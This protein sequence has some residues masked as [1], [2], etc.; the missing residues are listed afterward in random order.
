MHAIND[1]AA[2]L[3]SRFNLLFDPHSRCVWQSACGQFRE[4][5]LS[6]SAGIRLP[7][8]EVWVLPFSGEGRVLPFLEHFSSLTRIDYRGVHPELGLEL[9]M[10]V[11]APFYPRDVRLSTAPFHYVDLTVRRLAQWRGRRCSRSI[12]AGEIVFALA[13]EGLR[14]EPVQSGFAYVFDS[15]FPAAPATAEEG[16]AERANGVEVR[17][18][19]RALEAERAGDSGLR[20]AFDLASG[21]PVT[22]SMLWTCWYEGALLQVEGEK[23][24]PKYRQLFP[25][26][27]RMAAWALRERSAIEQRCEFLDGLFTGWS[28]GPATSALTA[29]ALHSW[30]ANTWW[31]TRKG[32]GDWFS[33]WDGSRYLHS[34]PDVQYNCGLFY[35]ALWP[36]LLDMQLKQWAKLE[37]GG[38]Q[39]LG[40][41]AKGTAFLCHDAG[42]GQVVGEQAYP[43]HMEV[44]ENCDFLLLLAARSFLLGERGLARRLLPLCRRL[45]EFIVQSDTS[46]S[47]F[48]ER[49]V[50]NMLD[51]AGAAL[52]FS[53]GQ[54]Y[55]A[56]KAQAA[57]WAL[58]E[59]E[60][61]LAEE[62]DSSAERWK[63]FASKGVKTLNERG[64]L[65]DHFAVT[66]DRSSAGLVDPASGDALPEGEL[67]GWDAY[68][69]YAP[70][71]L[72]YLF[73]ANV[74]MPRWRLARFAT[75][76]ENAARALWTEYGSPHSS[77]DAPV[78]TS[79]NLW[80]DYVAAYLGV[81][82]LSN[83]EAYWDYQLMSGDNP[84]CAVFLDGSEHSDARRSALR[85]CGSA[86]STAS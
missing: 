70:N 10:R 18:L 12:E 27:D 69:I 25:S 77:H 63:A 54:V 15:G 1:C 62:K 23:C 11:R 37:V 60:E 45:A 19:I 31:V 34:G 29:L 76:I 44:E 75:D 9:L 68:S 47:G 35:L 41:Q 53:R 85:A 81:D 5:R 84:G 64:W 17:C 78:W 51:D 30:L 43:H 24:R 2:T 21:E 33:V 8:G 22:L 28:L 66:V 59:L 61:R 14:F 48:P 82:M 16:R 71:G 49:G 26:E 55:L 38:Q 57:L 13:G 50:A 32:G 72:L 79:Q 86:G 58:A 52:Q 83:A 73:M 36:E 39:C 42:A 3:G 20:K 67:P 46:G 74:K 40:P 7:D 80:R 6:L 65:G 4:L 56:V